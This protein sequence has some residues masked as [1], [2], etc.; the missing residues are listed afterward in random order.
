MCANLHCKYANLFRPTFYVFAHC[1]NTILIY[2]SLQHSKQL[3]CGK[4]HRHGTHQFSCTRRAKS[5][6]WRI[7]R[8]R[9]AARERLHWIERAERENAHALLMDAAGVAVPLICAQER[10]S[11]TSWTDSA[12]ESEREIDGED[13]SNWA[14]CLRALLGDRCMR[15]TPRSH[16]ESSHLDGCVAL[17]AGDRPERY[18]ITRSATHFHSATLSVHY[19]ALLEPMGNFN[20]VRSQTYELCKKGERMNAKFNFIP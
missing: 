14:L 9:R 12:G 18:K 17:N 20:P 8:K 11:C 4:I 13:G 10:T 16:C 1:A 6:I 2:G 5:F 3:H 19:S 15:L 7:L